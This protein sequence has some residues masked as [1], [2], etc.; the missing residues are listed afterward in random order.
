MNY[1]LKDLQFPLI[2]PSKNY[3]IMILKKKIF[4]QVII[5]KLFFD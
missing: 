2:H 1:K 5:I 4:I 3:I